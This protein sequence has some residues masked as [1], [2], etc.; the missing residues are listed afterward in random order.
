[1][2]VMDEKRVSGAAQ[3]GGTI[4]IDDTEEEAEII[5]KGGKRAMEAK[6][7]KGE[8]PEKAK[9]KRAALKVTV[10]VYL[11]YHVLMESRCKHTKSLSDH[12]R[13]VCRS[14]GSHGEGER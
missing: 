10:T 3:V 12:G 2:L 8:Y 14:R 5:D 1:M 4:I 6:M 7:R 13:T 9:G 11:P